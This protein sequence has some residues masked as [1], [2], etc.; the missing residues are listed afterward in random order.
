LLQLVI[1]LLRIVGD[2]DA[3]VNQHLSTPIG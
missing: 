1:I 2:T 3:E